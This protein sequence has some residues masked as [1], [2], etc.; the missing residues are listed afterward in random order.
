MMA[1]GSPRPT[2]PPKSE[3]I[4]APV[5]HL[6]QKIQ[7]R[8]QILD[9]QHQNPEEYGFGMAFQQN[10][11]QFFQ[12]MVEGGVPMQSPPELSGQQG[13]GSANHDQV[14][15]LSPRGGLIFYGASWYCDSW[16]MEIFFRIV[17]FDG[18]AACHILKD[19]MALQVMQRILYDMFIFASL[20]R[21]I[22][23]GGKAWNMQSCIVSLLQKLGARNVAK[24]LVWS[25]AS[26]KCISMNATIF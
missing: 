10:Q 1:T 19:K 20:A 13:Y 3:Q 23:S 8:Q 9:L 2:P 7:Q 26:A 11:S 15:I 22:F 25:K 17:H 24:L 21:D 12:Q 18:K 16:K 14:S 4:Y 6:Q 5:A